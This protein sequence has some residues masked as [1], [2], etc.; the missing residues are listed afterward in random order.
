MIALLMLE[1]VEAQS[2]EFRAW[3]WSSA[4]RKN[5]GLRMSIQAEGI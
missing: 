4:P 1:Q 5:A 2:P 3:A